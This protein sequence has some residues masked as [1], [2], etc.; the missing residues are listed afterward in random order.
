MRLHNEVVAFLD[1][2]LPVRLQKAHKRGSRLYF[3]PCPLIPPHSSFN[4]SSKVCCL[5]LCLL[6]LQIVTV[7]T[8]Y[9]RIGRREE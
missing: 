1:A 6:V 9:I 3:E 5:G 8:A 4:P 2:P 7:V